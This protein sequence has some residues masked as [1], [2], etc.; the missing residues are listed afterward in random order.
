[1]VN[2]IS[3]NRSA[4]LSILRDNNAYANRVYGI[5]DN[6]VTHADLFKSG[7]TKTINNL[8]E[9]K[10]VNLG[11][12]IPK[13]ASQTTDPSR[14]AK[15]NEAIAA[16]MKRHKQI[17]LLLSQQARTAGTIRSRALMAITTLDTIKASAIVW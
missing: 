2:V 13:I 16:M 14:K 10:L 12:E 1:M 5:I 6:D 8:T 4:P 9:A 7:F 17:K 11:E 15:K 3:G